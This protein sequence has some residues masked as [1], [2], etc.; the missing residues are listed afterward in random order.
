MSCKALS[1]SPYQTSTIDDHSFPQSNCHLR[2]VCETCMQCVRVEPELPLTSN[3]KRTSLRCNDMYLNTKTLK[4]S[5]KFAFSFW[6][7]KL[8]FA[9]FLPNRVRNIGDSCAILTCISSPGWE[10]ALPTFRVNCHARNPLHIWNEFLCQFLFCEVVYSDK[11]LCLMKIRKIIG[12]KEKY[13]SQTSS[14]YSKATANVKKNRKVVYFR[15][16]HI[17][18]LNFDKR[19]SR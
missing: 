14:F 17:V 19:R 15:L 5:L 2:K 6:T 13:K 16:S 8:P 3:Y 10:K 7:E 4:T 12:S 1:I 18:K 9:C 11:T